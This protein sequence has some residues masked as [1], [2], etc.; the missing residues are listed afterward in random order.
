MAPSLYPNKNQTETMTTQA[1]R[2]FLNNPHP[3]SLVK[4]LPWNA[5]TPV[6]AYERIANGPYSFLLESVNDMDEA[7][8]YRAGAEQF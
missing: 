2:D 6:S 7:G 4:R 1:Q 8:L 3:G 5:V